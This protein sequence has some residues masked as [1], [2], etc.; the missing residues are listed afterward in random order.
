MTAAEAAGEGRGARSEAEPPRGTVDLWELVSGPE[1]VIR[2]PALA[3]TADRGDDRDRGGRVLGAIEAGGAG[4][5]LVVGC[6]LADRDHCRARWCRRV[7]TPPAGRRWGQR[8]C[9]VR[10]TNSRRSPMNGSG[11]R[12]SGRPPLRASAQVAETLAEAER[13]Y[14][15]QEAETARRPARAD[16]ADRRL[17][18]ACPQAG[19]GAGAGGRGRDPQRAGERAHRPL[20]GRPDGGGAGHRRRAKPSWRRP[21]P[22]CVRCRPGS[23]ACART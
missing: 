15:E 12:R 19:A 16:R 13:R 8:R 10:A 18:P 7:C 17:R 21:A 22:N 20:P 5:G 6:R 11:R 23:P 3:D 2:Q 14:R 9:F 1:D 4:N